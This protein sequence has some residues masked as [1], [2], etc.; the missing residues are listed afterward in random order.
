MTEPLTREEYD[1]ILSCLKYAHYAHDE[2][3]Y[4]SR[5]LKI[6]Q[7]HHLEHV[8]AKLRALR[9]GL[10]CKREPANRAELF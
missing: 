1:Y 8:E 2:T 5:E 6:M 7:E 3:H 4:A 10:E 9:D